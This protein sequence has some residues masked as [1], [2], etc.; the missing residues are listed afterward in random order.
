MEKHNRANG[1]HKR[2][3]WSDYIKSDK[4]DFMTGN[5]T[6]EKQGHLIMITGLIH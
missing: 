3:S 1:K 6:R 5:I 4:I 2:T